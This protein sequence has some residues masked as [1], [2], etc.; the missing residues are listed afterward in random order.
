MGTL[1]YMSPE[2]L[3]SDYED[4]EGGQPTLQSDVYA[5]GMVFWE[6]SPR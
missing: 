2:L 4:E 1:R 6:V 3:D 5:L